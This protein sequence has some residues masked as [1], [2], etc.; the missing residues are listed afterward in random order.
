MTTPTTTLRLG[1]HLLRMA[2]DEFGNH[3]CNDF[4]LIDLVPDVEER[5]ALVKAYHEWNGD[6]HEYNAERT[7][8]YFE[9]FALMAFLSHQMNVAA[10]LLEAKPG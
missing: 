2:A 9:D 6:P 10:D 7:Y 5:R 1:S 3:G 8:T 4:K